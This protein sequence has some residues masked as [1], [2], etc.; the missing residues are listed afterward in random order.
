MRNITTTL[1]SRDYANELIAPMVIRK[2][3][4]AD[5][6]MFTGF[7]PGFA[8]RDVI[9]ENIEEC[10]RKLSLK[11]KKII[12]KMLKEDKPFPFFPTKEELIRDFDDIVSICFLK[13]P[14]N[15]K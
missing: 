13:I 7:V 11:A 3:K 12:S 4:I 1:D 8:G 15:K 9:E 2:R 10:R 6:M 5:K 14:N